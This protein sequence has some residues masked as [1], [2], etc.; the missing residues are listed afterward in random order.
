MSLNVMKNWLT[1]RGRYGVLFRANFLFYGLLMSLELKCNICFRSVVVVY[2]D[3]QFCL[4]FLHFNII[5]SARFVSFSSSHSDH[6]S[7]I[8]DG[9]GRLFDQFM[10]A[11]ARREASRYPG[12]KHVSRTISY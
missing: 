2:K 7:S 10:L 5:L 6:F 12:K 9:E 1:K 4:L 11:L 8:L 3:T